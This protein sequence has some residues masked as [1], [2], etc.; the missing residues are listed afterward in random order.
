MKYRAVLGGWDDDTGEPTAVAYCS[1]SELAP[2]MLLCDK[3]AGNPDSGVTDV[4][5]TCDDPPVYLFATSPAPGGV[6]T[7]EGDLPPCF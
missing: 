4:S 5:I 7:W 2:L 3:A 1:N 6:L